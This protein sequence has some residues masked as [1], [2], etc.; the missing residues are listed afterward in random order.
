MHYSIENEP[1]AL[2]VKLEGTLTFRDSRSFHLMLDSFK[3]MLNTAEVRLN[4]ERLESI[5]AMALGM[6]LVAFDQFKKMKLELVFE[7]PQGQVQQALNEA[8]RHNHL[9]IVA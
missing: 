4:M 3:D 8:A 9:K 1:G 7:Q 2:R 6:L 5:D